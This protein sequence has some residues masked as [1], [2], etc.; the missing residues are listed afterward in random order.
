MNNTKTF[1]LASL[2]LFLAITVN[3]ESSEPNTIYVK[4]QPITPTV[5]KECQHWGGF[6]NERC[7]YEKTIYA[8]EGRQCVEKCEYWNKRTNAGLARNPITV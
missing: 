5:T 1:L 3:A 4:E 6:N 7:V 2:T 8:I